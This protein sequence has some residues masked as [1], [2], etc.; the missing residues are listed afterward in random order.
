MA[1]ATTVGTN[2]AETRSA[3][4]LESGARER[5]RVE[6]HRHDLRQHRIR[7]RT[8]AGFDPQGLPFFVL[9]VAPVHRI[10]PDPFRNRQSTRRS[11]ML[12]SQG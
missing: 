8:L 12:S 4:S 10:A 5:P 6:Y 7:A 9:I 2:T 3:K 1:M 11:S